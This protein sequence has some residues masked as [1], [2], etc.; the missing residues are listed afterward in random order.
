MEKFNISLEL[1]NNVMN[2]KLGTFVVYKTMPTLVKPKATMAEFFATF[3]EEFQG[4]VTLVSNARYGNYTNMVNNQRER[5]GL[6]GDF[7][8]NSL[9]GKHHIDGYNACLESDR[10]PGQYYMAIDLVEDGAT[11]FEAHYLVGGHVAT[12]AQAEFIKAHTRQSASNSAQG[13]KKAIGYLTPKFD[14]I[15]YIGKSKEEAKAVWNT[16]A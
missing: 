3:G 6:D 5:E 9:K 1:V 14:N 15:H 11:T 10:E 12:K 2:T 16:L 8:A 4:K 13:T 7:V